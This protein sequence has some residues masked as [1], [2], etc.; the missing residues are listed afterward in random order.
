MSDAMELFAEGLF[1]GF[2]P[3]LVST[4]GESFTD[5]SSLSQGP[6]AFA[7]GPPGQAKPPAEQARSRPGHARPGQR[8]ELWQRK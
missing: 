6:P 4:R 8:G 5:Q 2:A 7:P 3:D 1:Q